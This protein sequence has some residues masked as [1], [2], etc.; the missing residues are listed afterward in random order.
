MLGVFTDKRIVDS[1]AFS[2]T[3]SKLKRSISLMKTNN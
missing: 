2:K 1:T 3:S